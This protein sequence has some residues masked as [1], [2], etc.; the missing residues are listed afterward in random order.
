MIENFIKAVPAEHIKLNQKIIVLKVNACSQ[1][2]CKEY[3]KD[4]KDKIEILNK[5]DAFMKGYRKCIS[6]K[7]IDTENNVIKF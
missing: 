7:K 5:E 6:I 1:L 3:F 4:Y 2:D